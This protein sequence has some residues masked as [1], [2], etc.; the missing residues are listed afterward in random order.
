MM[1]VDNSQLLRYSQFADRQAA[2]LKAH[3]PELCERCGHRTTPARGLAGD[4]R[5]NIFVLRDRCSR[6]YIESLRSP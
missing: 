6:F 1:M 3:D 4:R 5:H 2:G